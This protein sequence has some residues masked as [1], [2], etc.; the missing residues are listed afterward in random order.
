MTNIRELKKDINY[1][2]SEFVADC[3][4][5]LHMQPAKNESIDAL[6]DKIIDA[7][8]ALIH[9]IHHPENKHKRNFTKEKEALQKRNKE[10]KAV[11]TKEF[12]DF[13]KVIDASYEELQ[14]LNK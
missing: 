11:I 2:C 12:E 10:H 6:A 5:M 14:S 4:L 7:R 9:T 3:Y 8:Y 13:L 1:L